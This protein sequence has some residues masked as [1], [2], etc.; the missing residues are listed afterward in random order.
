MRAITD[1]TTAAASALTLALAMA[2]GSA[3]CGGGEPGVI[4]V[5]GRITYK[6]E[7]VTTG[8]VYFSPES[9]SNRG[10]QG[11][12]DSNGN[13]TLGTFSANDGA[14]AGTY[15]VSVVSRGP[16]KPI[17]AKKV[18]KVLEEDMQGTGDPLIPQKY[19]TPD[20]SGLKAEVTDG[21]SNTFDFDLTD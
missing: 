15:K 7:P 5:S 3:G 18:G 1:R 20:A 12:L 4:P 21:G 17:P 8:E 6:G 14:Y 11:T 9:S 19:F 16:D 13:Y 2:L 10:A